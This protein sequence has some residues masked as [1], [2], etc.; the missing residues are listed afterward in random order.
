MILRDVSLR[1]GLQLTGK[2]L[3]TEEK[4]QLIRTLLA[5]GIPE[6][7]IGSMAR[8]ELVPPMA[9]SLDVAAALSPAELERCWLWVATPR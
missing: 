1:D 8:G 7:E 9:D 3:T 2:L 5:A 4:V 6:L